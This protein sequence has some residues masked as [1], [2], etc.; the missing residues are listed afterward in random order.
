MKIIIA[1]NIKNMLP[2]TQEFLLSVKHER[3]LCLVLENTTV[4]YKYISFIF[5]SV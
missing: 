3:Q 2:L 1:L 5:E 4:H